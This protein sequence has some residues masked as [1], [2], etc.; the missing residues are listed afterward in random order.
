MAE[1]PA[2]SDDSTVTLSYEI[3]TG[4]QQ[5]VIPPGQ[6]GPFRLVRPSAGAKG[7][8]RFTFRVTSALGNTD[9]VTVT[10]DYGV[11]RGDLNCDWLIN[12]GDINPFVPIL[13]NPD[14]WQSAYPDCPA[15]NGDINGDESVGFSDINP[16]VALLNA[17]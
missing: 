17:R 3:M 7:L 1:L 4:P 9:P 13:A 8:D 5:A 11:L 14:A 10:L 16:F 2:T 6:S 12:F 15:E